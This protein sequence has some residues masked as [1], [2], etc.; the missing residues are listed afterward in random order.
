MGALSDSA[1]ADL[2]LRERKKKRG[3]CQHQCIRACDTQGCANAHSELSA[4][5]PQIAMQR[6]E[7]EGAGDA[8][9]SDL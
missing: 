7:A 9:L 1:A 4:Q 2:L 5:D 3:W 8:K 6:D